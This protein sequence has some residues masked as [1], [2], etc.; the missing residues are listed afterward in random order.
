[1]SGSLRITVSHV[2][3]KKH[4]TTNTPKK[5]NQKKNPNKKTNPTNHTKQNQPNNN[6]KPKLK[7]THDFVLWGDEVNLM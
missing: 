2:E 7:K 3:Q 6:K 5:Q 1:M 4:K